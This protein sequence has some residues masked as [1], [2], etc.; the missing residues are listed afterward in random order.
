MTIAITEK[1]RILFLTKFELNLLGFFGKRF[2]EINFV[3]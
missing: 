3:I 2:N 1:P